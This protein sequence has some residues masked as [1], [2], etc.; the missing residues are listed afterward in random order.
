MLLHDGLYF[1]DACVLV[2]CS[3][4]KIAYFGLGWVLGDKLEGDWI[5]T[6]VVGLPGVHLL[7]I[8]QKEILRVE[9]HPN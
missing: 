3:Y 9:G 6:P 8:E 4:Q 2:Q 1:E 7:R 5:Q